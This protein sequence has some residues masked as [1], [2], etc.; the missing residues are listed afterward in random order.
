MKGGA[1]T[2]KIDDVLLEAVIIVALIA[3]VFR[4]AVAFQQ[5]EPPFLLDLFGKQYLLEF[6]FITGLG[7]GISYELAIYFGIREAIAAQKRKNK[8]WWA[9]LVAALLQVSMG[10][11]I[12]APVLQAHLLN[13]SLSDVLGKIA[14]VWCMGIGLATLL[15]FITISATRLVMVKPKAEVQEKERALTRKELE[16]LRQEMLREFTRENYANRQAPNQ[17]SY[18]TMMRDG[19]RCYY[20]G[21]D[22]KDWDRGKIHVDHFYPRVAG[23]SDEPSNLVVSCESCNLSKNSRIPSSEEITTFKIYLLNSENLSA[24][25]RIWILNHLQIFSSQKHMAAALDTSPSYVSSSI[26]EKPDVLDESLLK[27][28][29]TL[30]SVGKPQHIEPEPLPELPVM[31]PEPQ[32][33]SAIE[34][35]R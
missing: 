32:L 1:A 2:K 24:K 11:Y 12:V 31:E 4:Y 35:S 28:C 25:Q 29:A 13:V 8:S 3:P 20:C 21:V 14:W 9:P 15:T 30:D 34:V 33:E 26:K 27:I 5:V 22:M 6:S 17:A 23:G 18:M 16:Q 10:I 19:W 7:F